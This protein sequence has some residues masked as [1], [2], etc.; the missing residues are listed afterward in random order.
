MD[1]TAVLGA[2]R[3]PAS[4]FVDPGRTQGVGGG[5]AAS[6]AASG[7]GRA[8]EAM[9]G[10]SATSLSDAIH[11]ALQDHCVGFLLPAHGVLHSGRFT[12][13][14]GALIEGEFVGDLQCMTGSI[15]IGAN[16]RVYG[17]L[18]AERLYIEG[19]VGSRQGLRSLLTGHSLIAAS[20]ASRINADLRSRSWSLHTGAKIWGELR[21]IGE[22]MS[23]G[24]PS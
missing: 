6:R 4:T 17:S 5:A 18:T 16:A 24:S 1:Q 19:T 3:L 20:A 12:L 10:D 11:L 14:C 15:I 21:T 9:H 7:D 13:A 8:R 22:D 23:I 2:S